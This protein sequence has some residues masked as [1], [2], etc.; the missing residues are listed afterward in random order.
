VNLNGHLNGNDYLDEKGEQL[1]RKRGGPDGECCVEKRSTQKVVK[2]CR[3]KKSDKSRLR[4]AD[5][6]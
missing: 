6:D 1:P 4:S 3:M 5:T 2:E